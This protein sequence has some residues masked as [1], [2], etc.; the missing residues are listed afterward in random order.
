[1][2]SRFL[3]NTQHSTLNTNF[4]VFLMLVF[5]AYGYA[6]QEPPV[7]N[8]FAKYY[9]DNGVISSEGTMRDGKPDAYW[10]TYYDNGNIKSEGN[11]KFFQLDSLWKFYNDAGSLVLEYYYKNGKKNGVRKNYDAN[12]KFLI[13]EENYVN[14]VKQLNTLLYFKS[15]KLKQL[16]PFKDGREEGQGFEYD[17][18]G[19]IITIIDYR[20]D[21]IKKQE[22]INRRD[23]DGLKQNVWKEF[24]PNGNLKNECTFL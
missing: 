2:N 20:A 9:Y 16:I 18:S 13:S 23:K 11:G 12:G 22:K 5:G 10:K 6:Q 14:D 19:T 17:T 21:F 24:Y 3:F 4:I 7:Q 15:G 8:G 1:M